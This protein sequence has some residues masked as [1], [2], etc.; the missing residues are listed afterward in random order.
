MLEYA[1]RC[2]FGQKATLEINS[3]RSCWLVKEGAWLG[4]EG[5]GLCARR[6]VVVRGGGLLHVEC[7]LT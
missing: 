4:G 6:G 5:G 2:R 3:T 7:T 1:C